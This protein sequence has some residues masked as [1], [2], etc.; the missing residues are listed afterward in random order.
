[1]K[2]YRAKIEEI[3]IDKKRLIAELKEQKSI[4]NFQMQKMIDINLQIQGVKDELNEMRKLR[5]KDRK[6]IDHSTITI[7]SLYKLIDEFLKRY[8]E[9]KLSEVMQSVKN[10][11]A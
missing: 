6:E 11:A 5:E 3:E 9:V 8:P 10:D 4:N 7:E 1:M 2:K